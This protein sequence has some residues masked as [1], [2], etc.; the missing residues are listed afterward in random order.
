[1]HV[2]R[3]RQ[4]GES[5]YATR[6]REMGRGCGWGRQWATHRSGMGGGGGGWIEMGV[7]TQQR[8][9]HMVLD[10]DLEER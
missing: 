6:N 1:M 7:L 5:D 8:P 9:G 10:L 2:P 3:T 4:C